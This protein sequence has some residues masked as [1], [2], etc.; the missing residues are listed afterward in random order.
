MCMEILG[1]DVIKT[2][3]APVP[4]NLKEYSGGM[5]P[6]Y[7]SPDDCR[8]PDEGPIDLTKNVEPFAFDF[9][10]EPVDLTREPEPFNLPADNSPG[11]YLLQTVK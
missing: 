1:G 2:E 11:D 8:L 4:D 5:E 6:I 3:E 7:S 9:T 10:N